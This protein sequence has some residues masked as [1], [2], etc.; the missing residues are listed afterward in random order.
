M[1]LL[2]LVGEQPIPIL[3]VHR[4][5]KPERHLLVCTD[6]TEAVARQLHALLPHSELRPIPNAYQLAEIARR[7]QQESTPDTV[8]NLTGGTK[9][10]AWAGYEI[11]LRQRA[12]FVYLQSEGKKSTLYRFRFQDGRL[13]Q[14]SEQLPR[15]IT[16]ED[17]L[18]AHGLD[19]LPSNPLVN[20][21]EVA[22]YHFLTEHCDQCLHNL[23]Y[24]AFE[25]DFFIQRGN[26]TAVIEA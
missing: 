15:L 23:K 1:L 12:D 22:V 2:S 26:Q 10:M 13:F 8:F 7:F 5:L 16:L 20:P 6:K 21:Q 3:L 18:Q 25:I 11:A 4:A 17:Y 24:P 19:A 14:Q 9:P